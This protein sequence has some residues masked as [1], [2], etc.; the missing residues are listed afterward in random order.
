M[1]NSEETPHFFKIILEDTTQFNKL[2]IPRKFARKYGSEL[3]GTVQL[4]VPDGDVTLPVEVAKSENG[5]VWLE[6]GWQQF[7]EHYSFKLGYFL[8]FVY[9]GNGRFQVLPFDLSCAAETEYP[10]ISDSDEGSDKECLQPN[11]EEEEAKVAKPKEIVSAELLNRTPQCL[12]EAKDDSFNGILNQSPPDGKTSK[13]S[14]PCKRQRK[15][16]SDKTPEAK[17][18]SFDG[19]SNQSPPNGK[20]RKKSRPC[21]RQRKTTSDKTGQGYNNNYVKKEIPECFVRKFGK[22]LPRTVQLKAPSGETWHVDLTK[23]DQKV[24]LQ[25]GW[26]AFAEHFSLETTHFVVFRFERNASFHVFIFDRTA[27]EIEYPHSNSE[28]E[29]EEEEESLECKKR[30]EKSGE[31]CFQPPKRMKADSVRNEAGTSSKSKVLASVRKGSS[32]VTDLR[33]PQIE[34]PRRRVRGMT[35]DEIDTALEKAA[36]GFRTKYPSFMLLI[37]PMHVRRFRMVSFQS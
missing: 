9:E 21:K 6:K 23:C 26:Q 28:E 27:T 16:T 25:Q 13:K 4:T 30:K 12:E 20:T 32:G 29:E 19:I 37:Q 36:S 11:K 7:S 17:D 10:Y 24:Y 5:E 1:M 3:S 34:A 15:T 18:N 35:A 2:R 8:V 31:P 22:R 33:S 14:R